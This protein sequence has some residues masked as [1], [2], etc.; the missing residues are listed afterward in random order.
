MPT[1]KIF[2]CS[3]LTPEKVPLEEVLGLSVEKK[4]EWWN[5]V[6][7]KHQRVSDIRKTL[8]LLGS[9]HSGIDIVLLVGPPGVGKST[10]TKSL[11]DEIMKSSVAE[12]K[13]DPSYIPVV[14]VEAPA[15]GEQAFSWRTFYTRVGKE[16]QE[17]LNLHRVRI[18]QEDGRQFFGSL[19]SPRTVAAL[20]DA[21]EGAFENRRTGLVI[22]DEAAHMMRN[23]RGDK[24]TSH[25]DALKSLSNL[26][27][28]T[29]ALVGSYDLYQVLTLNGQLA[30]RCAIVHFARYESGKAAD[31]K[32]FQDVIVAL[33]RRMP[34]N[35]QPDLRALSSVL[36]QA[37]IG[38]VG[39]LKDTLTR[40]LIHALDSGGRWNNEHLEAA[41]L[42]RKQL[43]LILE[44][45]VE[46]EKLIADSTY[47]TG[48]FPAEPKSRAA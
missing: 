37:C 33:Q 15:S 25:M 38:N 8:A 5:N 1:T 4:L 46:G 44:E 20:R 32:A 13:A 21:V 28:M 9:P 14:W 17:P 23:V 45:T 18:Q 36:H 48:Q 41:L 40:A 47:G 34:L 26:G 10:L 11:H 16:L 19:G 12:M 31:R 24:L 29:W 3:D 6:R 2:H 43:E 42:P 7:V 30:R 22:V 39:L 27:S 35:E